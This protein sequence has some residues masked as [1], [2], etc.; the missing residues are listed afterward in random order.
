MARA[1]KEKYRAQRTLFYIKEVLERRFNL[2]YLLY[3]L[4]WKYYPRIGVLSRFPFHVDIETTDSCNLRCV[5]CVH[6]QGKAV[7]TGFIDKEFASPTAHREAETAKA[8]RG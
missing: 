1:Y 2:Q 3:R 5:M 4:K 8:H 7:N 6:G